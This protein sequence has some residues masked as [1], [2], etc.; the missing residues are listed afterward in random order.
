[1]IG[2][3]WYDRVVDWLAPAGCLGC[4]R[5][6]P[7]PT[8]PLGLC[9]GCVARLRPLP[10]ARCCRCALPL[11]AQAGR[12]EVEC[13]RCA[14]SP[15]AF[16]AVLCPW[17]YLAP[18][19][20]VLTQLKFGR[21]DYLADGLAEAVACHAQANEVDRVVPVPLHWWRHGRRGFNQ[22]ELLAQGLALRLG[23][24]LLRGL[25]RERGTRAQSGL[26]R[27]ERAVNLR[28]AFAVVARA[29]LAGTRVLLVDDIVT[30]GA[31]VDAAA[32]ALRRAGVAQVIVAAVART[33]PP[34]ELP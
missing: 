11:A 20:R 26:S 16:D 10:A 18:L 9:D 19:D 31:T 22:A 24:P 23:R 21:L 13:G 1:M 28:G 15:P 34:G 27:Q 14:Q 29:P 2:G 8:R 17:L 6:I 3:S 7:S 30:T 12:G 25:R 33:P 32:A 5:L 4:G